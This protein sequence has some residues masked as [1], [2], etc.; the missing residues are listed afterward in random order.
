MRPPIMLVNGQRDHTA[1]TGDA[2]EL[3]DALVA[4]YGD[5]GRVAHRVVPELGAALIPEP[6]VEPVAQSPAAVLADKVLADWF[7]RHLY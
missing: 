6:G 4:R 1:A 5:P 2:M 3:H 7:A